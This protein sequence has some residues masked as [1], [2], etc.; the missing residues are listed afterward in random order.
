MGSFVSIKAPLW[1]LSSAPK[2]SKSKTQLRH[3]ATMLFIDSSI[4]LF[5]VILV[6]VLL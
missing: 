1:R 4:E 6:F 2:H 5:L 3:S